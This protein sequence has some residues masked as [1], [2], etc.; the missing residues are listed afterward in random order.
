VGFSTLCNSG[1]PL[2]RFIRDTYAAIPVSLPDN[3]WNPFA[4][5]TV[6]KGRVRYL[7][8][9]ADLAGV[10]EVPRVEDVR[11]PHLTYEKSSE[12]TWALAVGLAEPFLAAMVGMGLGLEASAKMNR[13]RK[14]HVRIS[15]GRSTRRFCSAVSIASWLDHQ[16]VRLPVSLSGVGPLYI[17]DSALYAKELSFTVK[18]DSATE[19]TLDLAASVAGK[20]NPE[21]VLR[22]SSTVQITGVRPAASGITCL[23]V[24]VDDGGRLVGLQL[25]KQEPHAAATGVAPMQAVPHVDLGDVNELMQFDD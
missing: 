3:R 1:D 24:T 5:F 4:I 13:H 19:F 15:L 21:L 11:L 20:L 7:G 22:S 23:E 16:N 6:D 14:T 17:V 10:G 12:L 2:L 8:N 25:P 18:G 9:V